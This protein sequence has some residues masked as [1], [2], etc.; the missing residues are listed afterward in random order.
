MLHDVVTKMHAWPM[1]TIEENRN[2]IHIANPS[3]GFTLLF[4]HIFPVSFHIGN[5]ILLHK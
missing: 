4:A 2:F 1:V 3:L 5:G